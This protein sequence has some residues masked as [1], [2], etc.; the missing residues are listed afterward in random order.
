MY[1]ANPGDS[2]NERQIGQQRPLLTKRVMSYFTNMGSERSAG[3][4]EPTRVSK[5]QPF[6]G[7]ELELQLLNDAFQRIS[8]THKSETVMI[9]GLSGVGKSSL[10]EAFAK[11][12]PNTVLFAKG[13]FDIV[14]CR[15]PF[16][17]LVSL[18]EHICRQILRMVDSD[19][20]RNQI[21]AVFGSE[22]SLLGNLIPELVKLDEDVCKMDESK[23]FHNVSSY[24]RFK[25][26]FRNFFLCVAS[27]KNPVVCFLDDI[28]W[29]DSGSMDILK[30]LM[31]D[32]SSRNILIL[33]TYRD[34]E[35]SID[36][37][38]NVG[39]SEDQNQSPVDSTSCAI[40][41]IVLD[42][43]GQSDLNRMI[44]SKLQMNEN[45]TQSLSSMIRK[46]TSGNPF[47]VLVFL[48]ML[49]ANS[50]LQQESD[51]TW[52]WDENQIMLHT[53]VSENLLSILEGKLQRIPIQARSILQIASFIGH[54]FSLDV[55]SSI[56]FEEQDMI[57]GEYSF[58]RHSRESIQFQVN[59][60]LI[61]ASEEG[62]LEPISDLEQSS[63]KFAHEKIRQVLYEDL[64]PDLVERQHLHQRIG[65]LIWENL[66][67]QTKM[68]EFDSKY[69]FL[70]ANNV[71]CGVNLADNEDIVYDLVNI[72]LAASK[73][74][75]NKSDFSL[76]SDYLHV[77]RTL[78]DNGNSWETHYEL[79]FEVYSTAAKVDMITA[80]FERCDIIVSEIIKRSKSLLDQSVAYQI[81]SQCLAGKGE[82]K[83]SI[84]VGFESLR[85]LGFNFP[86]KI[87]VFSVGKQYLR[88]KFALGRRPLARLVDLPVSQDDTLKYI[89][90]FMDNIIANSFMLGDSFKEIF[91][92]FSLATFRL[93]LKFG[94]CDPF[95]PL[96]VLFWGAFHSVMGDYDTAWEARQVAFTIIEKL[97]ADGVRGRAMFAAWMMIDFWKVKLEKECCRTMMFAYQHAMAFGDIFFAQMGIVTWVMSR[98]YVDLPLTDIQPRMRK[99]VR[100]LKE[101]KA[102]R[103][104]IFIRPSWQFVSF[105]D[106]NPRNDI[107]PAITLTF[108][109]AGL[110]F[111]RR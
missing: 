36:Y 95:A 49:L 68:Y 88:A 83:E 78:L 31:N 81:K 13:K 100:E 18:S 82:V 86:R 50:L 70:A 33:C 90:S 94:L 85:K 109:Y 40:T 15:T 57:E 87:T 71:N 52:I 69:I 5:F 60:A 25:Q 72:N 46:K 30:S 45:Q 54:E 24:Q 108:F 51:G 35:L 76:A 27:E 99:W 21:R 10:V 58:N 19:Q 7:R 23:R 97:Q 9:Q 80:C 104:L 98:T 53:S 11:T 4:V 107:N 47:F 84:T 74:A 26:V 55:L 65:F 91:L 29:A 43:L 56:L 61:Q 20:I 6:I 89:L 110:K 105:I 101:G 38:Q 96:A 28:Q 92:F 75:M 106:L 67:H 32:A 48:E 16:S 14:R 42:S 12:L 64:M 39:L 2:G 8:V 62:L 1:S 34:E 41:T 63:Y 77:A 73:N 59:T 79:W 103:A 37:F 93:T 3:S 22:L 102:N 17:G 44:A 111:M 66:K